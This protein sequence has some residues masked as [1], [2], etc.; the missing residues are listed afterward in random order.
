[1][2]ALRYLLLG[3]VAVQLAVAALARMF[4]SPERRVSRPVVLALVVVDLAAVAVLGAWVA[5][6]M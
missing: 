6:G 2:P 3:M 1:M 4:R 5:P